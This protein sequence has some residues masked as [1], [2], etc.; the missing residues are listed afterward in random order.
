[1]HDRPS[2]DRAWGLLERA[3]PDD[4]ITVLGWADNSVVYNAKEAPDHAQSFI[5]WPEV[6]RSHEDEVLII[7]VTVPHP[8]EMSLDE[9]VGR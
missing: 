3:Y 8:D 4:N 2:V 1:M 5:T 6:Q 9:V 7:A